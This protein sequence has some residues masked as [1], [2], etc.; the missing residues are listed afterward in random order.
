MEK[1]KN[2]LSIF[3]LYISLVAFESLYA[4]GAISRSLSNNDAAVFFIS[5]LDNAVVSSPVKVIFGIKNMTVS[6]AGIKKEMSGHHHLI[7]NM[8]KLPELSRP[9]PSDSN[10]IH[11]GKGQTSALIDL[12]T[13][14]HTL[15]LIFADYAHIPHDKPLISE[16]ITIT[17]E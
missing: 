2:K 9:I 10:H 14:N 13:G 5:P 15:Q 17:V 6:P 8:N 3:L 4:A 11:F 16:R 1:Q 7:I 12:E